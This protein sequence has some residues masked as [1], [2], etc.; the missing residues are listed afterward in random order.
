[1][2]K[3]AI[4]V[5]TSGTKIYKIG[6]GIVFSEPTC[7]TVQ[8]DTG[9]IRAFGNEAKRL[10]GKTADM[11]EVVF[12]VFEGEIVNERCAAAYLEYALRKIM[13]RSSV[14]AVFCVPCAYPAASREKYYRMAKSAGISRIGFVET[15]YLAALGQ[16]MP[17]S[18]ANPVFALDI[19]AGKASAACFSL[20]GIIAGFTINVGGNNMDIHIIDHIA[21]LFN[22]KIGALTS[23][24]L[25][26]TVGSFIPHD[27]QSMIVNGRDVSTGRPRSV[28]VA[29]ADILF[30]IGIYVDKI[31]EY[32]E[33][34]LQKLPA[35]VSAAMCKNGVLLSGGVCNLPGFAD[36]LTQKL[37]MDV[38]APSDP[39]MAVVLGGGRAI[40]NQTLLRKLS[41]E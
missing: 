40:G 37:Q 15:P 31:V 10:L 28:S 14:E 34:L 5:G 32:C 25:K 41:M 22:L 12:P 36:Y 11:T 39:V 24:K 19:G 33:L 29:S 18:E 2:L 4:D 7:V 21:E 23:E 26:N 30:P 6:S 9:E 20:D 1:M 27:N 13:C 8:K 17:L 3:L 38:I 35:E 16:D